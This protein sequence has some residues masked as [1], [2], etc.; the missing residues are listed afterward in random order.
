MSDPTSHHI[1]VSV[2][3]AYLPEQSDAEEHRYAFAYTVTIAN[4]GAVAA[5]LI[6]RH[7]VITDANSKVQEVRGMGVVGEQPHLKPG[8]SYQY[9][10]GTILETPLG[11]MYG[12]YQM[13]GDDGLQ[14]DAAI[15]VF[16]LSLPHSLH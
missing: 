5:K 8:E 11:S 1:R 12:S 3:T 9:T 14:F 10:S 15:P 4:E 16:T 2:T 6:S 13:V 7:W